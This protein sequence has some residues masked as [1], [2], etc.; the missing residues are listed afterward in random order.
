MLITKGATIIPAVTAGIPNT[1]NPPSMTV[2]DDGTVVNIRSPYGTVGG[3]E[4]DLQIQTYRSAALSLNRNFNFLNALLIPSSNRIGDITTGVI[5]TDAG[6]ADDNGRINLSGRGNCAGNHTFEGPL[7]TKSG[8][9]GFAA[10]EIGKRWQDANG[11]RYRLLSIPSATTLF[12]A[13]EA[14]ANG[15]TLATMST[16]GNLT[17]LD[18]ISD[19]STPFTVTI[20]QSGEQMADPAGRFIRDR[21]LS[22]ICDGL[23]LQGS[24]YQ[25]GVKELIIRDRYS[26]PRHDNVYVEMTSTTPVLSTV[27]AGLSITREFRFYGWGQVSCQEF[28]RSLG[29]NYSVAATTT[30]QPNPMSLTAPYSTRWRWIPGSSASG[31]GGNNLS[32]PADNTTAPTGSPVWIHPTH[33]ASSAFAP[34]GHIEFL[35]SSN[36]SLTA[37]TALIARWVTMDPLAPES[38]VSGRAANIPIASTSF[39]ALRIITSSNKVYPN[40]WVTPGGFM[41]INDSMRIGWHRR[42]F[43][44]QSS[45]PIAVTYVREHDGRFTVRV[46]WQSAHGQTQIALPAWLNGRSAQLTYGQGG[47]L[48]SSVVANGSLSV[49]CT[50]ASGHLIITLVQATV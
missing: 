47:T 10:S 4:Y 35:T 3:T 11:R 19:V 16:A 29:G 30:M 8:G 33:S 34:D 38:S 44:P 14:D 45:G 32:I 15:Y 27:T 46:A 48:N 13:A 49:T 7:V 23:E 2:W 42:W 26:I 28:V 41:N 12:F 22:I 37:A 40:A 39:G 17:A 9:H 18:T 24:E 43:Q 1:I 36:A 6:M 20:G 25:F 50:D 31:P 5:V 21:S